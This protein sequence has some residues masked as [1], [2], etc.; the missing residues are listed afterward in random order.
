MI[1]LQVYVVQPGDTLYK[2]ARRFETP[3]EELVYVNQLQLPGRL[4]VGQALMIPSP[5]K[6]IV[7]KGD[8]LYSIGKKYR[9]S[10]QALIAANP[11]LQDPD[12][13]RIGQTIVLPT[14]LVGVRPVTANGYFS[15]TTAA[16]LEQSLPDL[17]LLSAFS[18]RADEMGNLTKTYDLELGLSGKYGVGNLLAVTNLQEQGGFSGEIAHSLLTD[19]TAQDNLMAQ[20]L[21]MLEQE[22]FSGVNLDFEYVLPS[23]R[24]HYNQFLAR[25]ADA[26]HRRGL[27]LVTALA[28]KQSD[29]QPG[30]LYAAHDYAFHGQAADFTVLMCY[31]W[32]YTYSPPRAVAP[33]DE[34]RK[35]LEFAV[36]EIP[37]GKILLGIPNYGY[38]W[39]LPYQK[40]TAAKPVSNVGAVTLA[41]KTGAEILFD[42]TAQSPFFRCSVEGKQHEVWFEDVRSL[43]AKLDLVEAYRLGGV[44]FWNLNQL[45]RANFLALSSMYRIEKLS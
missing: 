8:S 28:P 15:K 2:L 37:E 5:G 32:G 13:L 6:H 17:S 35:V 41:A 11:R 33:V 19:E 20:L 25:L 1:D 16:V 24:Q 14:D 26:L 3:M 23:D 43:Q 21:R 40:G 39:T 36:G 38:D 18:C 4:C 45:F 22:G 44:S 29:D 12:H 34:I 9:I 10:L 27:L 31:E 30:L 7:Q 42:E